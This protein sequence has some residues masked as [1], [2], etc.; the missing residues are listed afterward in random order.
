[1]KSVAHSLLSS[2]IGGFGRN[3]DPF[4]MANGFTSGHIEDS[5]IAVGT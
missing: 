4:A 3:W 1:L 2:A 5:V